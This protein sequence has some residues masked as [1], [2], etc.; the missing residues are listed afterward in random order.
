MN[1]ISNL[2][3]QVNPK[4]SQALIYISLAIRPLKQLLGATARELRCFLRIGEGLEGPGG[5]AAADTGRG[6]PGSLD[7]GGGS[8]AAGVQARAGLAGAGLAADDSSAFLFGFSGLDDATP[9]LS[10]RR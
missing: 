8:A 7:L 4:Y 5:G 9:L 3:Q 2:C 6:Q 10:P 1:S